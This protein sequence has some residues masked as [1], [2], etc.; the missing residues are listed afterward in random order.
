LRGI[1]FAKGQ[2]LAEFWSRLRTRIAPD[3]DPRE[4]AR[5]AVEDLLVS[6]AIVLPQDRVVPFTQYHGA[7][8]LH[9]PLRRQE[10]DMEW[11]IT[12]LQLQC[13]SRSNHALSTLCLLDGRLRSA[14]AIHDATGVIHNRLRAN[15]RQ[16]KQRDCFHAGQELRVY[17]CRDAV[18]YRFDPS[19]FELVRER[20]C[21]HASDLEFVPSH[22]LLRTA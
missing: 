21:E 12:P 8:S 17:F 20:M 16:Y 11:V 7:V 22:I 19:L 4:A 14:E 15:F 6:F 3:T 5:Q 1:D 13:V 18:D 2:S 10:D 9:L